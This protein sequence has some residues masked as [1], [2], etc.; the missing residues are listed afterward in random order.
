MPP[1]T[2][3]RV[4]LKEMDAAMLA[5]ELARETDRIIISPEGRD[6]VTSAAMLATFLHR[7]QTRR[8][9]RD[10]PR[11][12]YIEHPLRNALRLIRWGRGADAPRLVMALLHDVVEDCGRE[13]LSEYAVPA[14]IGV[15][16]DEDD[17]E[18]I[19]NAAIAWLKLAYGDRVGRAVALVTN[20][21]FITREQYQAHIID[22]AAVAACT[23]TDLSVEFD[24]VPVDALLVKAADLMDNAG[25]LR[26][27]LA[28]GESEQ[29]VNH[30]ATKYLPVM[31]PV[32]DALLNI[33]DS[34]VAHSLIEVETS[35]QHIVATTTP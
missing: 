15:G 29:I 26:H 5:Y 17:L 34:T 9:R 3:P 30:L 16:V 25:S 24:S 4:P 33:G 32:I 21:P 10:L 1:T 7:H 22:L 13:I 23:F 14:G 8:V 19:Q 18:S 12:P 35:L 11:V 27:Q 20:K 2:F 6:M 31:R 28:A